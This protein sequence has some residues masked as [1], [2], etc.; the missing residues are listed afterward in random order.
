MKKKLQYL[1]VIVLLNFIAIASFA[2]T[3]ISGNINNSVSNDKVPAVSITVKGGSQGT[4]TDDKGKFKIKVTKLPA[5]LVFSS[6]GYDQQEITVTD[7]AQTLNVSFV[8]TSTLGQD[9]VVSASRL[10]EKVMT[11][12]VS[13]ER[14]G[15]ATI[16]NSPA[17]DYYD[18]V[19][20]LKG[21]DVTNSSLT[22]TSVTTR[23]FNGSGNPRFNQFVDGMD[24]Q[25]PGL[26][27]SVGSIVGPSQLD[28]DNV[29]L[30]PGASSALYGSGGMNGTLLITSKNPFKYQGVS[31]EVKE[32][33][34]H[35]GSQDP[36]G[37]SPYT[38]ISARWGKKVSDRFAFKI[39]GELID[40]KDWV[41]HDST[42]YTGAGTGSANHTIPGTRASD[43]NYNGVNVYGDDI[44]ANMQSVAN[45]V[46][47][48]TRNGLL[49]ASGG[50]YDVVASM[51]SN[52][53]ANATPQQIQSY[54]SSLPAGFQPSVTNLVPF[55]FGLRNNLI[56]NQNVSR[57]GYNE[58]Q[59]IN[60]RTYIVKLN[61]GLYYKLTPKTEASFQ[62]YYGTGNSVYTGSD[63]YSLKNLM[64]GQYKLEVRNENWFVKAYTTQENSGDAFNATIATDLFDE[65]WKPSTT[66]FPQYVAAYFQT[67]AAG[68]TQSMA[69]ANAR[70]FA[71][72][73]RPVAGSVNFDTTFNKVVS[74]AIPKGGK[75]LDRTCLYNIDGQY[76]LKQYVKFADVLV[77]ASYRLYRLNSQGTLFA[78]TTGPINTSE[79]GAYIQLARK[80]I[81]DKLKLTLSGRYDKNQNFA[82][83]FTPR[84]AAVYTVAPDQNIRASYQN[85]YRFP[86]NQNQWINLN[87]GTGILIGGL[88]S[89]RQFYGFDTKPVYT[90]ASVYAFQA[91]GG[92]DPSL[93]VQ[94]HFGEYKPETVNSYEIGYKGL[95]NKR[96]LID[97][98]I[99]YSQYKDF[100]GRVQ[101]IQ[102]ATQE[103]F[104]VSVN[105]ANKVSTNGYGLSVSYLLPHNFVVD[106]N[107]SSDNIDNPD[108][109]F[110]T[111][112]N[113]PKYRANIGV[114]NSGFG[115]K[116]L[117]G[118]NAQYRWQD[119]YY[120]ESDFLQGN[121]PAFGTIDALVSY[122]LP[123]ISA[124][125]KV[126]GTNLLNHYY[127]S[128]FANPSIGGLYYVS[129]AYNIL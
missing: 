96:L 82:G 129:F 23:G 39:G 60:P 48:Q 86:S 90:P 53:P 88:P 120:T 51:N 94:Q 80:F 7:A 47:T 24:N 8:P 16:R 40:A 6:I 64:I 123:K 18:I 107:A 29:E 69:Y 30:L 14:I 101:A 78:D 59:I 38:N 91:G 73:G 114:S 128:A 71:D 4:F 95:F 127:I 43:P 52:L 100:I 44:N 98:Y 85:A 125:I 13:I 70:N 41:A 75:F 124:M 74:Q 20:T 76:N 26:S 9:V 12:P 54:I 57:T 81:D 2:Q 68:G 25:A 106:V 84:I 104:S 110:A 35:L 83:K 118:F 28:V 63:R 46:Q 109:N 5:T 103:G 55:Y 115:H 65:A 116:K 112:W 21:V 89:L 119:S 56:P 67:I 92:T 19:K 22:F 49:A 45:S 33:I 79:F 34:M 15:I 117:F 27:F 105:S 113:T 102:L 66:W 99:Y 11:S 121:V 122:K 62:A 97:A 126:G 72:I 111:Y 3:T 93:L 10:P 42:N 58:S 31:F 50:S 77:G 36:V 1:I 108:T 37:V 17:T 32:G 61:A 87:T